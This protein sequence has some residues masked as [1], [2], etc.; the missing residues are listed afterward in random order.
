[1]NSFDFSAKS[2]ASYTYPDSLHT[3]MAVSA[4][5]SLELKSKSLMN[6]GTHC[7]MMERLWVNYLYVVLGSAVNT[8][9]IPNPINFMTAGALRYPPP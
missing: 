1:M 8:T 3:L 4:S 2:I 6:N 7:R 5:K 9:M